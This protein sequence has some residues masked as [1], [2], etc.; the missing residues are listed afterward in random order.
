[1]RQTKK[2]DRTD[3]PCKAPHPASTTTTTNNN[4]IE[5]RGFAVGNERKQELSL[6]HISEPTRPRLI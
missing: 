3:G 4:K 2:N 1:M 5:V 6:I